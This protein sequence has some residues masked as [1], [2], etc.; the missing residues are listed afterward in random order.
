M[1]GP[2]HVVQIHEKLTKI[3]FTHWYTMVKM[4]NFKDITQQQPFIK[5]RNIRAGK[6]HQNV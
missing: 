5:L 6:W 2:Q 4:E 3:Q 1:V